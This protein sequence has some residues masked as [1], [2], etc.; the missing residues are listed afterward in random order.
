MKYGLY[1][2]NFGPFGDARRMAGLAAEAEAAGWDGFFIIELTLM[3][4]V[5]TYIGH[6]QPDER[7]LDVVYVGYPTGFDS[8]RDVEVVSAYAKA[9]VTWWLENLSVWRFGEKAMPR[10]VTVCT[11]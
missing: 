5:L 9:G 11:Q 1:L 3:R 6:H 7:A 10:F 8:Q 2:P 4:E